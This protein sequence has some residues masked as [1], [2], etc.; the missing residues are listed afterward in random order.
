[1]SKI[2][3]SAR[4]QP[5]TVRLFGCRNEVATTVFAH[6]PSIEKGCGFKSPDHWGAFACFHCHSILDGN[7]TAEHD[8]DWLRA[9]FETQKIL[10]AK[11]L[12]SVV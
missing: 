6:A 3:R 1:M 4:M 12:L 2:T 8:S 10:F 11:G 5:C 7:E 9:I